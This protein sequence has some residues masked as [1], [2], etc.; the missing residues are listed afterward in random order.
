LA[1]AR[2]ATDVDGSATVRPGRT[3]REAQSHRDATIW[4]CASPSTPH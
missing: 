3:T 4:T 1:P 2:V